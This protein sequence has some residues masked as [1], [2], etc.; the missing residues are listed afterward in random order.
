MLC[1]L[2][3]AL[4]LASEAVGA[5]AARETRLDFSSQDQDAWLAESQSPRTSEV[6]PASTFAGASCHLFVSSSQPALFTLR[7]LLS[8]STR[9][10]A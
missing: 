3:R 8:R 5:Q 1:T 6:P 10:Q 4:N 9:Q 2:D 7:A